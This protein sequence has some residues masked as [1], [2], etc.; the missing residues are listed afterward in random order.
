MC[1][2]TNKSFVILLKKKTNVFHLRC[3]KMNG[4]TWILYVVYYGTWKML[5]IRLLLVLIKLLTYFYIHTIVQTWASKVILN[6]TKKN[7]IMIE[8]HLILHHTSNVHKL[9]I[10]WRFL[11]KFSKRSNVFQ[12]F[13]FRWD[14][15]GSLLRLCIFVVL[16]HFLLQIRTQ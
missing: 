15:K 1:V 4:Q 8:F 9:Y 16:S 12:C 7:L 5:N 14:V 13:I 11:S 2:Q 6:I 3:S 10:Y